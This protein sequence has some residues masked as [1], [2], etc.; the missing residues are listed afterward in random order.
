MYNISPILVMP[1]LVTL[2]GCASDSCRSEFPTGDAWRVRE[3]LL[4]TRLDNTDDVKYAIQNA[5]NAEQAVVFVG[6]GW[7]S[8]SMEATIPYVQFMLDY[9]N[10]HAESRLL[11]HHIDCTS[12]SSD[13]SPLTEIPGWKELEERRPGALIHGMGEVVWLKNDRV[14]H[15]E[16]IWDCRDRRSIAKLIAITDKLMAAT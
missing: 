9:Y 4:S 13:Y 8:T 14:L 3:E 10:S 5:R 1:I 2:V 11:F 16:P 7:S 6:L 15:V 12:I